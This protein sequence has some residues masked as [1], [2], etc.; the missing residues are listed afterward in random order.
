MPTPDIMFTSPAN[1]EESI[2]ISSS[3]NGSDSSLNVTQDKIQIDS[4]KTKLFET[5]SSVQEAEFTP[6]PIAVDVT[7]QIQSI[8]EIDEADQV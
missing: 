6:L 1:G 4:P 5:D 3:Q 7:I 8:R 2:G